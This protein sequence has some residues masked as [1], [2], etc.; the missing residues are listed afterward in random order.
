[1]EVDQPL[2]RILSKGTVMQ[3][4]DL[5]ALIFHERRLGGE[6]QSAA[7]ARKVNERTDS[8]F[9]ALG[10]EK[11]VIAAVKAGAGFGAVAPTCREIVRQRIFAGCQ[12]MDLRI[13]VRL[14]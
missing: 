10:R 8:P 4:D 5:K 2:F 11:L 13:P 6:V 1:M 7:D 3:N 9:N 12:S 14:E